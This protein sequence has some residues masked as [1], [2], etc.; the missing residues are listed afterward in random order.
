MK[1]FTKKGMLA[2][3]IVC[4]LLILLNLALGTCNFAFAA[5]TAYTGVL[6]DLKKDSSFQESDY[7]LVSDDYSLNIIQIAESTDKRL[8]VYVYHPCGAGKK[9]LASSINL[10]TTDDYKNPVYKNYGLTLL[11]ASGVF[12]KYAVK[13]FVVSSASKRYYAISSILRFFDPKVDKQP[14]NGNTVSEVPYEVGRQY[15]IVTENG[16]T[17]CEAVEIE[18]IT[19]TDKFVGYVRYPGGF[20]FYMNACDSHFVAFDTDRPM[21][22]LMEADVSYM[23]Q[24]YSAL[25]AGSIGTTER[26][27]EEKQRYAYLSADQHIE[28]EGKG[29]FA[30]KY[31]W[32]RIETVDQFLTETVAKQTVYSGVLFNVS[33][34]MQLKENA[35]QAFEGKKWVL[36]F[37]ETPYYLDNTQGLVTT[38]STLVYDVIILRL[39][40]ETD[41]KVYNLGVIDNKQTG[42]KDPVNE[43]PDY[44]VEPGDGIKG[45]GNA[46][47][48]L[49]AIVLLVV[50]VVLII[51]IIKT[52]ISS[53]KKD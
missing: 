41:G 30:G 36:R 13:D 39:K 47:K 17:R 26:F 50:L 6:D 37:A 38:E 2:A 12:F 25:T 8:Y 27:G 40:F 7:P 20:Y 33:A 3:A 14:G 1:E 11:N 46:W 9:L 5:E 23:T 42:S 29:L 43:P 24:S 52:L 53:F 48:T 10:S 18:T 28:Y 32:A 22:K 51:Y 19:I 31:E 4:V 44:S 21:D 34:G 35:K 49:V 16:T 15:C 45:V